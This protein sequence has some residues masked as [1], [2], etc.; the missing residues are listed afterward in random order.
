[1]LQD[2]GDADSVIYRILDVE[3]AGKQMRVRTALY[4]TSDGA[5]IARGSTLLTKH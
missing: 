3:K 2:A 5:Q 4:R 1:V